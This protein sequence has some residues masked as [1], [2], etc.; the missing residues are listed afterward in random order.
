MAILSIQSAVAYGSVGNAAAVFPLQ[1]LGFEVWRVDTVLFSNHTG[2][3]AWRGSVLDPKLVEEILRGIEERGVLARCEAVLSGYLGSVELG[4]VVLEAVKRVKR[5][6]PKALYCCDPVL[7]DA[8]RGFFVRPELAD[9]FRAEA[10]PLAD[11]STPNRFELETLTGQRVDT[12]AAARAACDALLARGP[13]T[14]LVTSLD[15][16]EVPSEAAALLAATRK[17]GWLVRTPRLPIVANGAGDLTAA[18]FLANF[19]KTGEAGA[20]LAQTAA[21]V[22]AVI[23]ETV[24]LNTPELA[25]AAAQDALVSPPMRCLAERV[26]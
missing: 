24:R 16:A 25:I 6:N 26:F 7:G 8:D 22:H 9:F 12:L 3:G 20:A 4:A 11:I 15:V 19:L 21:G 13:R 1:R 5:A 2:Y 10:V 18:L 14:I 17:G 23:A